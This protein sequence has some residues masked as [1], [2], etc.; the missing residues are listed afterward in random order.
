MTEERSIHLALGDLVKLA[1]EAITRPAIA[2]QAYEERLDKIVGELVAICTAK[3]SRKPFVECA[4]CLS[5]SLRK[6]FRARA[7]FDAAKVISFES[8]V[9]FFTAFVRADVIEAMHW[10]REQETP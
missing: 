1:E 5:I 4:K 9:G 7:S 3:P 10:E 8:A 2:V 6:L